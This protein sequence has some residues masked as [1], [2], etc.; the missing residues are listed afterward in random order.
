[1]EPGETTDDD[2]LASAWA[3]LGEA[4][5]N[6]AFSVCH[7]AHASVVGVPRHLGG[8]PGPLL[9]AEVKAL[10][11]LRRDPPRPYHIFLGGAKSAT[12][13]PLMES[14]LE[15][16]CRLAVGGGLANTFFAARGYEIG[17][18]L[19]E[20]GLVEQARGLLAAHGSRLSLPRVVVVRGADGSF[21]ETPADAVGPTDAIMDVP[22][23]EVGRMV[24]EAAGAATVFWNGAFGAFETPGAER[25]TFALARLLADHRGHVVVGGG[26]TLAATA[27]A[28]V[29]GGFAHASTG[30]GATLAFLAGQSLPGLAAVGL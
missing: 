2:S 20:R 27:L 8:S 1:Y 24:D 29:A 9:A 13:L 10:T 11:P 30:G 7:R 19:C 22:V 5:V 12:K 26:E 3:G 18:S 15:R 4:F 6:D 14:L 16:A 23:A 21:R 25:G 17:R 28:G